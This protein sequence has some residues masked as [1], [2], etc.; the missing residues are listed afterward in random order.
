[1]HRIF[2]LTEN[3]EESVM[4]LSKPQWLVLNATADDFEDLEHIYRSINLEF[5]PEQSG[6]SDSYHW[7]DAKD[8]VP[9][10]EIIECIR[11][12]VDQNLI[13]VRLTELS[14]PINKNDLSYLWRGWF[15]MTPAARQLLES[16]AS[17]W[18]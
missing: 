5:C 12:L 9:L 11:G 1:M 14:A 6:P 2:G 3:R 7:T 13:I 18:A 17:Q 15:Q 4:G 8:R 10:G 16:S